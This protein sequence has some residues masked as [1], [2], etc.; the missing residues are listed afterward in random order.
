MKNKVNPINEKF[1]ITI[2]S[3]NV[4][5]KTPSSFVLRKSTI[6]FIIVFVLFVFG[7]TAFIGVNALLSTSRVE[8]TTQQLQIIIQNQYDAL[9][10]NSGQINRLEQ[11]QQEITEN[12]DNIIGTIG[13]EEMS[14]NIRK[15]GSG[16]LTTQDLT[17]VSDI[18]ATA[19]TR[20]VKQ[21][22][23]FGSGSVNSVV[24]LIG[25]F[26]GGMQIFSKNTQAVVIDV[27]TGISFNARRFGG[28]YHADSEPLTAQDTKILKELN[29]GIW[30]WDRR[31]IW[32]K[33]GDR[34]IAASM[35]NMP[36]MVNPTKTN[37]FNGHFCIHFLGSMVH[38]TSAPC[39]RHQGKVMEAFTNADKLDEYLK[40]NNY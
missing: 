36:H 25:W 35:N 5:H 39:S 14:T 4:A 31:A 32:V 23:D 13:I 28:T 2:S 27:E 6:I 20:T 8:R 7:F 11:N 22:M 24:E 33:I 21:S 29:N 40:T 9:Q 3:Q 37:N 30:T 19:D 38:E 16:L 34:Y 1:N 10:E 17:R 18:T 26:D 12:L 15:S